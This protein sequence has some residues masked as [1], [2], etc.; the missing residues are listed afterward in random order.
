VS[1]DALAVVVDFIE[2]WTLDRDRGASLQS[3]HYEALYP[4]FEDVV[5]AEYA[6]LSGGAAD[7]AAG[8]IGAVGLVASRI[9]PYETIRLLGEGGQG[10][11]YEATDVRL[12][13]RVAIKVLNK[14]ESPSALR[15][16][17]REAALLASLDHPALCSLYEAGDHAGRPFLAM[18]FVE[19][20][21]LAELIREQRDAG[22]GPVRLPGVATTDSVRDRTVA[23]LRVL[24]DV[25]KAL[26]FAHE[27]GVV[28]RD[29]KPANI[30]LD[31][32]GRPVVLDF[33]LARAEDGDSVAL[34]LSGDVLGTPAYL[35]PEHLEGRTG[36]H[37]VDVYGLG[38]TLYES[39]TLRRPFE[40]PT[41]EEL[42]KRILEDPPPDPRP[43]N[44]AVHRD[45]LAV[46]E[47]S[48]A[49]DPD[50]RYAS[51]AALAVDLV[52][53]AEGRPVSVRRAGVVVRAVQWAGRNR[54]KAAVLAIAIFVVPLIA[55][56]GGY[57]LA[58]M[59]D[60]ELAS[61]R[62]SE[63]RD[64]SDLLAA[65]HALEDG[66][67]ESAPALFERLTTSPYV[68]AEAIAGLALARLRTAEP[69]K[70]LAALDLAPST[71]HSPGFALLRK[72]ALEAL[73]RPCPAN[74]AEAAARPPLEAF[75]LFLAGAD[76][77]NRPVAPSADDESWER[78]YVLLTRAVAHPRSRPRY[79][80]ER[81]RVFAHL[82]RSKPDEAR[83]AARILQEFWPD[84]GVAWH[85]SGLALSQVDHE[86][87]V[88]AYA[89]ARQ[90]LPTED[91]LVMEPLRRSMRPASRVASRPSSRPEAARSPELDR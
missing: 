69:A 76:L 13:R 75:D 74:V 82:G 86:A 42:F 7:G 34:T 1:S 3:E 90:L 68:G 15:R 32:E 54:T 89:R 29:V 27:K 33:G 39:L 70:A 23:V 78:A 12:G 5:R 88:Q 35:A 53:V 19:G 11:V 43:M 84:S 80:F 17:R 48:L 36:D 6:Q 65:Y 22:A 21:S 8:D 28:H 63:L 66:R 47:A 44:S 61:A 73:G 58:R 4:G 40:A 71:T 31:A 64:E 77:L 59:P 20:R 83:E 81:A 16:F 79:H 51:A 72:R 25:A 67:R 45:L 91:A 38:V 55:A 10:A 41:R 60:V 85:R 56:L 24:A 57:I 14:L 9:G 2:R 52:A 50:R 18:R 62:R 26:A 30:V 49:K 46:I 87:S 37:R